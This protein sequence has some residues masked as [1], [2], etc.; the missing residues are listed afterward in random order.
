LI[1][2]CCSAA[3]AESVKQRWFSIGHPEFLSVVCWVG[4]DRWCRSR[5]RMML[6]FQPLPNPF[7]NEDGY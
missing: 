7:D 2:A 1:S 5:Q 6:V 3:V 4:I